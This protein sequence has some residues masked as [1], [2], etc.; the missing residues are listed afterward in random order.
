MSVI[1]FTAE[2]VLLSASGVLSPGPPFLA[3]LIYGSKGGIKI[4]LG[5][6]IVELP[7]II[8]LA[9]SIFEYSSFTLTEECLRMIGFDRRDCNNNIFS[10]TNKQYHKKTRNYCRHPQQA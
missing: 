1:E 6:T 3:N 7:L 8:I 4:A 2:V 9:L 10:S 5:H